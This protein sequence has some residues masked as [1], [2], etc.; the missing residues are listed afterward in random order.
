[1]YNRGSHGEPAARFSSRDVFP[2][3][4]PESPKG[5]L[6][7]TDDVV[8][9]DTKPATVLIVDDQRSVAEVLSR[10]LSSRGLQT[11]V[12]RDG[13]QAIQLA[14]EI[15]PE[16]ILCDLCMNEVSGAHVWDAVQRDAST[17]RIPFILMTG[18]CLSE[19]QS[20]E[21]DLIL[22]KPFTFEELLWA[23][24]IVLRENRHGATLD[25]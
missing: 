21:P 16:V 22:Q 11:R 5:R 13:I 10:M 2:N 25:P 12:A 20:C 8:H 7:A 9:S 1:M 23:M 19:A 18:D 24:R 17:S 15:E 3:T 6:L 4:S 14:R